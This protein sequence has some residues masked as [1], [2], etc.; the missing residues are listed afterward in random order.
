M[1]VI[2]YDKVQPIKESIHCLLDVQIQQNIL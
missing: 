1:E 2:Y